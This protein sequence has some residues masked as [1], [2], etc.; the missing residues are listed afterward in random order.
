MQASGHDFADSIKKGVAQLRS[1]RSQLLKR[2]AK[3]KTVRLEAAAMARKN[4]E[5]LRAV[6]IEAWYEDVKQHTF[7]TLF[8]PI[9][10]TEARAIMKAHELG[11][12]GIGGGDSEQRETDEVKVAKKQHEILLCKLK[13]RIAKAMK[14]FTPKSMSSSP[15]STPQ[16]GEVHVFTKLSS[17]SPKDSTMCRARALELVKAKLTAARKS[18]AKIDSNT[19]KVAIM[20]STIESLRLKSADEVL[21]CFITS[22]RV[23]EDD[24]PLALR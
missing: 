20:A 16:T 18:G 14:S 1:T 4:N 22:N 6:D 15:S 3:S 10:Q 8:V 12:N 17:R 11:K 9:E 13:E 7:R 24:L 23:C 21:E 5:R 2:E 19:V